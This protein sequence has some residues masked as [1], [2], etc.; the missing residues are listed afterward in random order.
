MSKSLYF[1]EQEEN[2]QNQI[3]EPVNLIVNTAKFDL[4]SALIQIKD[5]AIEGNINPLEAYIK[6][7]E[8][9]TLISGLKDEIKEIT[10]KE[11]IKFKEQSYNGY[12]VGIS[13]RKTMDYSHI[14]KW[15][16]AKE[17]IKTIENAAKSTYNTTG[18][19]D[20]VDTVTGEIIPSAKLKGCTTVLTLKKIK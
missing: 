7:N 1:E 9:E 17:L 3:I 4:N 16:E 11:A 14:Q 20:I 13:E 12:L 2:L 19:N 5:A 18:G 10:N 6:F 15:N 8:I